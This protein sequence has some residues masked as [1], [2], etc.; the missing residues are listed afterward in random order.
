[1]HIYNKVHVLLTLCYMFQRL[2]HREGEFYGMLKNIFE[3]MIQYVYVVSQEFMSIIRDL[4]PELI[5]GKRPHI[6]M[7]PIHNRSGV[8]R[9]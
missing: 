9:F 7:S 4:I 3:H 6:D 1:M 5:L 2:R 8:M